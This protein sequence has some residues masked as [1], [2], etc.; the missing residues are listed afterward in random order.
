MFGNYKK[1]IALSILALGLN[2]L[3]VHAKQNKVNKVKRQSKKARNEALGLTNKTQEVLS[4]EANAARKIA[5]DAA[6]EAQLALATAQ[7]RAQE[8]LLKE[9]EAVQQ[10]RQTAIIKEQ[11]AL[12]AKKVAQEAADRK[13]DQARQTA[14]EALQRA[15]Q[16]KMVAEKLADQ[17]RDEDENS[18][19]K[20]NTKILRPEGM[21]K[22]VRSQKRLKRLSVIAPAA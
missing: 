6:E 19:P 2:V 5:A 20:V 13:R 17:A 4:S 16:A 3:D 15:E 14:E 18:D 1:I 9:E 12:Q 22:K 8:A 11:E 10:A 21:E 7:Q